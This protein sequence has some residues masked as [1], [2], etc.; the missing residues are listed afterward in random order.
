M[1]FMVVNFE[2][3]FIMEVRKRTRK[4]KSLNMSVSEKISVA[5]IE[6]NGESLTLTFVLDFYETR[7]NI[8]LTEIEVIEL[9]KKFN[10]FLERN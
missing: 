1:L 8:K 4:G 3:G 2:G 9:N 6:S 10:D 7:Y 5:A